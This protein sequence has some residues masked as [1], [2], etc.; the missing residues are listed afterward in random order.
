MLSVIKFSQFASVNL[1]NTTNMLVGVSSPSGGYNFQQPATVS[2]ITA[3]RPS[4]PYNG[5]QGYNTSLSQWEYWNGSA[6]VQFASGGSGTVNA[7]S[8][9][10]LA[11]YAATGTAVSGLNTANNSVLVTNSSGVPSWS[12]TLP[13]SLTIPIPLISGVT[14]GSN[15]TSGYVG[16]FVSSIVNSG[17]PISLTNMTSAN[18]TSISL[19]AGDWDVWGN[20]GF[21]SN[22]DAIDIASAWVSS[23]SASLPDF[24]LFNQTANGGGSSS[25][26]VQTPIIRFNITTTTTIYLSGQAHFASGTC[27]ACGAIYARRIR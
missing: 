12:T 15:A 23:S 20:I 22:A 14:T 8:I 6:W 26:G 27:T 24:S 21:I 5:L 2:W 1:T 19:T 16:E 25:E 10:E 18:V 3:N 7:G 13:S 9:N 4:V 17:S 11:W